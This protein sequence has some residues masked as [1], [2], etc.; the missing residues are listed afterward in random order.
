M[1]SLAT[2]V[3]FDPDWSKIVKERMELSTNS[4]ICH[5][6][7]LKQWEEKKCNNGRQKRV[8]MDCDSE[9]RCTSFLFGLWN[10]VLTLLEEL[11]GRSDTL[12]Q[13]NQKQEKK[14]HSRVLDMVNLWV[15]V[16]S[17]QIEVDTC[18]PLALKARAQSRANTAQKVADVRTCSKKICTPVT[19]WRLW[20]LST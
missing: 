17:H 20:T 8:G 5:Q 7:S 12:F 1:V 11:G 4:H 13:W 19:L 3:N 15:A 2:K 6:C 10:L 18:C 16:A 14:I 9:V